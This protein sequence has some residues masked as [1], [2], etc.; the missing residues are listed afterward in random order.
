MSRRSDMHGFTL[1]ELMIVVVLL[2]IFAAIAVPSF[3]QFINNNRTQ[4][5]NNEVFA[6][7][8]YARSTAVAQRATISVCPDDNAWSVKEKDCAAAEILRSMEVTGGTSIN[9]SVGEIAFRHNGSSATPATIVT[10]RQDDFAN[11][12]TIKVASAG[13]IR[14]YPRGKSG[15]AGSD[16]MDGCE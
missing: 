4:A 3:T 9:S 11:G 6:L 8:Q 16:Y 13:S 1:I 12:Y 5:A 15:T 14:T 2:G 7:L 10:C